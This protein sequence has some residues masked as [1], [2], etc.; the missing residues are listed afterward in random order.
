LK[1]TIFIKELNKKDTKNKRTKIALPTLIII[2]LVYSLSIGFSYNFNSQ[3][4]AEKEDNNIKL[5]GEQQ[6]QKLSTA[7][8]VAASISKIRI[9]S[10]LQTTINSGPP[11][12]TNNFNLTK[13]FKIEPIIWNMTLSSSVTFDDKGNMYIAESGYA[14]GGLEATP[15]IIKVDANGTANSFVD[16]DLYGPITDIEY[17]ND[18]LYVS[19]RAKISTVDPNTAAVKDIIVGLRSLGDF[20]NNQLAFGSD[21][22]LYFG[23][24]TATNSGIIG[25]DNYEWLKLVPILHN[26]PKFSDTPAKNVTLTGTNFVSVDNIKTGAFV[27]FGNATKEGQVIKGDTKC[28]GCILSANLD[29]T[30]LKVVGWGFRNPYG[31]AFD[32]DNDSTNLIVTAQGAEER[33]SRPIANDNDKI[34]NID[35][36]SSNS[37]NNTEL[38]YGWP[39]FFGNAEPVTDSKFKSS[40]MINKSLGFLMKDHPKVQRPL[41]LLDSSTGISQITFSNN[42]QFGFKGMTLISE[43]GKLNN[44]NNTSTDAN[45]TNT[46]T[47]RLDQIQ[48]N[49][50]NDISNETSNNKSWN[51]NNYTNKTIKGQK[52]IVFDPKTKNYSNFL[53]IKKPD[54]SFR[55]IDLK[56]NN[57]GSILYVVSLAKSEMRNTTPNNNFSLPQEAPWLYKHTGVLWKISNTSKDGQNLNE[58]EKF[59]KIKLSPELKVT[60]NSGNVPDLTQFLE[61]PT[62]YKMI[63]ILWNMDLPGSFAFDNDGNTY[64]ASTG[65]TYGKVS[66]TPA[67]YKIDKKGQV[68]LVV[69]RPLHGILTDIEFNKNNGLLYVAHRN[70]LSTVN[71]TTGIVKDLVVGLPVPVYVTHPMGQIAIGPDGRVYFSVGGLSNTAVPDISDWGIGWIREMPFMHEIPGMDITLTGQNFMSKN[72]ISPNPDDKAITGGMMPFG[73]PAVEGQKIQGNTRC[74]SCILSIAPDGSD[75]RLHAWGIRNAYGLIFDEKGNLFAVSNGDD[76]KGIR[77]VTYDPDSVFVLDVNKKNLTFFGWP[78]FPGSNGD[79]IIG[80]KFNESPVQHYPNKPLIKDPPKVTPP[81]LE[82]GMSVGNAQAAYSTND[83]F[84]FKGKIF[85]TEFGTIAPVTHTFHKPTERSVGDIMGKIIGQK[86]V[87]V[88]PNTKSLNGFIS[89]NTPVAS[90]RPVG[91]GFTN[92]GNTLYVSSIEKEVERKVTPLGGI[93]PTTVDYPSLNTGTVW[94]IERIQTTNEPSSLTMNANENTN[95]N[96]KTDLNTSTNSS[97]NNNLTANELMPYIGNSAK[98]S[99]NTHT[100]NKDTFPKDNKNSSSSLIT[101]ANPV[102]TI[103][104]GAPLLREFAFQPNPLIIQKGS[105]VTWN[106]QDVVTHTVTS[107][108]GFSDPQ[109]GKQ[110]DSGLIGATYEHIFKKPGEYPYF[111]QVHPMM[112]GKVIVK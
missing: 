89:L 55:P 101:S 40:S 24:G 22:R 65:V 100:K 28:N 80:E 62:G 94:K 20:R 52:I 12:T 110:F 83:N 81:F 75:L 31:L 14:P 60:L 108:Y 27:P 54:P 64:V 48:N 107:G 43:F 26:I 33:G 102:A 25:K 90:F 50:N 73:T 66:T 3:A 84:G 39:D 63:P 46:T 6:E 32:K 72:F 111:C 105:T 77:R 44:N 71:V 47:S 59:S 49:N 69:D 15:R 86:I 56:F 96:N 45:I 36:S 58:K 7:E 34:Y 13:G 78:D 61:I 92:D 82:L 91:L 17:Y 9:P 19:N 30:D 42:S 70:V 103:V 51:N 67:I 112:Q 104:K 76:D 8:T 99:L 106:N 87:M 18:K 74:T 1:Y 93:L 85:I 2:L 109:M 29:G 88:D 41:S 21:D 79:S 95:T 23:Q 38:F 98:E 11:P 37:N 16:R 68:S 53:S 97:F 5:N 35:T 10:D 4:I 57:D